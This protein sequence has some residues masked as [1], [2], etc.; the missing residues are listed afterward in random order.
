MKKS[1]ILTAAFLAAAAFVLVPFYAVPVHAQSPAGPLNAFLL[2]T[3]PGDYAVLEKFFFRIRDGGANTVVIGPLKGGAVPDKDYYPNIVYLAHQAGLRIYFILPV[4]NIPTV[5]ADHP[6]W[7]DMRYDLQSGT[8]QP[9]GRLNLFNQEVVA[10]LSA[11]FKDLASYSI[12]GILLGEDFYYSET[13][14]MQSNALEDYK[15]RYN[16]ALVPGRAIA[17]VGSGEDGPQILEYGE[18]FKEWAEIKK[19]RLLGVL[20]A[21]MKAGKSVNPDIKFGIPLHEDGLASPL[22]AL[23]KYAYDMNEFRRLGVDVYW[24]AIPHRDIR[25]RQGL[26]YKK[27]MEMIARTAQAAFS[28]VKDPC[29]ALIAIQT[30][31]VSGKML[32]FSEIEEATALVKKSGEM[33]VAF[34]ISDTAMLPATLTKK[35]FKRPDAKQ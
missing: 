16:T 18:G 5:L 17:R 14:G 34:M 6:S 28:T 10:Y 1:L 7:E 33:C 24:L 2:K 25:E 11:L 30:T 23:T 20:E 9:T 31:T 3:I 13:E 32:S 21:L 27:S 26:T 12:D 15:N 19:E 35:L 22:E 4:R 8:I 29:R